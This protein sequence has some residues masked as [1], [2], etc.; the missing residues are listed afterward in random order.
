MTD[1]IKNYIVVI[2]ICCTLLAF[3]VVSVWCITHEDPASAWWDGYQQ[4]RK[5]SE[6]E[7]SR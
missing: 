3:A 6:K 5:D 4:G 7:Y 1:R 2:S